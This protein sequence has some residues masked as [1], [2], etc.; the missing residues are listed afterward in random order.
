[1]YKYYN[2]NPTGKKNLCDHLVR[3]ICAF[4]DKTWDEAYKA[5]CEVAFEMKQLPDDMAVLRKYL[6]KQ[7]YFR[8]TADKRGD[9]TWP[10]VQDKVWNSWSALTDGWKTRYLC[11]SRDYAATVKHGCLLDTADTRGRALYGYWY[12]RDK[13]EE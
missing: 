13:E 1:M 6:N 2:P 5:L 3:A 8:M 12:K 10:R 11:E 7:G 4:E 9:G